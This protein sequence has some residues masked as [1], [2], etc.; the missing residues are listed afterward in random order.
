MN[1]LE[2]LAKIRGL[3]EKWEELSKRPG[4]SIVFRSLAEIAGED[5]RALQREMESALEAQAADMWD[6]EKRDAPAV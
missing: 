1:E 2:I 5:L 3:A 6:K 4:H